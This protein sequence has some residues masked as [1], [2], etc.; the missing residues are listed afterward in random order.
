MAPTKGAQII[1]FNPAYASRAGAQ[2]CG[3]APHSLWCVW[4]TLVRQ[5]DS[6]GARQA[7]KLAEMI[8][9]GGSQRAQE[10]RIT[11]EKYEKDPGG[12]ALG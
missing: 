9:P 1:T 6:C 7:A 2:G 8:G 5:V 10:T 3:P 12:A 4:P 11:G